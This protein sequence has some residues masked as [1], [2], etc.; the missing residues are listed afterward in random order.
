MVL[1]F[2]LIATRTIILLNATKDIHGRPAAHQA[3]VIPKDDV[4]TIS[5]EEYQRYQCLLTTK[6]SL[7][8]LL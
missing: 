4:M 8:L 1:G 6:T 5:A 7:P 3:T 2:A